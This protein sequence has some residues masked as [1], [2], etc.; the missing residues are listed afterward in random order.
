M[1][2]IR[3]LPAVCTQPDDGGPIEAACNIVNRNAAEQAALRGAM[4]A[5]RRADA[6]RQAQREAQ[7]RRQ[8][9]QWLR[10]TPRDIG[11]VTAGAGAV[12]IGL[13]VVGMCPWWIGVTAILAAQAMLYAAWRL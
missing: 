4:E 2:Q 9:R 8:R 1:I 6:R 10:E 12:L 11:F 5:G 7:Q 3:Q 13:T